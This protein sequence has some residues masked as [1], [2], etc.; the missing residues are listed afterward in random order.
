MYIKQRRYITVFVLVVSLVFLTFPF[1]SASASSP[2]A[3]EIS[4]Q[5][6]NVRS[7]PGTSH[8]V[9]NTV[10]KDTFLSI[11]SRQGD[12]LRVDLP[13]GGKGWIFGGSEYANL[14][15]LKGNVKVTADALNVR[16]G[17]GANHTIISQVTKDTVL[18]FLEK[19]EG[20]Y[21][22]ILQGGQAGWISGRFVNHAS[23]GE[24]KSQGSELL[25]GT[26]VVKTAVLNVRSGPGTNYSV[27][28]RVQANIPLPVLE[29]KDNWYKVLLPGD[30]EGWIAAWFSELI[31]PNQNSDK[32]AMINVSTL[33][34]RSGPSTSYRTLR[35]GSLGEEFKIVSSVS[36]WLNIL[37]E[38]TNNAWI[39][40]NHVLVRDSI[41]GS[42]DSSE[43]SE[44]NS[45]GSSNP[46]T[47]STPSTPSTPPALAGR[48]IVIDPG[49]GGHDPGAVG[50]NLNL[51]EKFVNLDTSLRLVPL[52]E[53]AG[54][55]VVMTRRTDVFITLGQRVN[56]AHNNSADIFISIHANGHNNRSIGGTETY[57]NTSFRSQ[58]SY[59]LANALQQELVSE[60]KLRN[61]GTKTGSFYV[62]RNTQMPSALVELAFLSNAG[63]EGLLNQASFRQRGAEAIYRGI[64]RYFQ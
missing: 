38:E 40:A 63:E 28:G 59:R 15:T 18:P 2:Q 37:L 34:I 5:T 6:L 52:L 3:A 17:P 57:Y 33:N 23:S 49:H 56:I 61:I 30:K 4:I 1:Q 50:R 10:S 43:G 12:W 32:T 31:I 26:A 19:Q 58:D 13:L 24:N 64:L 8:A 46:S 55:N 16:S 11:L 45:R 29:E 54:A 51:T 53:K 47:L 41:G 36:G 9:I 20:W 62:I 27:S 25:P 42:G 22:V 39:S 7:G 35:R 14:H 44:D 48:T 21:K 60:L